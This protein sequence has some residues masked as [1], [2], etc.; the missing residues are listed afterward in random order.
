V[1]LTCGHADWLM[2]DLQQDGELVFRMLW[3]AASTLTIL[4]TGEADTRSVFVDEKF[5]NVTWNPHLEPSFDPN[6]PEKQS[7][8]CI[9]AE[10]TDG[11]HRLVDVSTVAAV[12][13][14]LH[15][16]AGQKSHYPTLD[17]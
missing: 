12:E 7:D 10:P 5:S 11:T 4:W 15:F 6:Q 1:L 14:N 9:I 8:L 17:G 2:E 13:K 16:V 3:Q